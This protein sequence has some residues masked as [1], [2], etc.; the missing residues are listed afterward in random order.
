MGV[1]LSSLDSKKKKI[2]VANRPL[3]AASNRRGGNFFLLL[4]E[5]GN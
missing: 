1:F 3:A 4:V 5:C 2:S